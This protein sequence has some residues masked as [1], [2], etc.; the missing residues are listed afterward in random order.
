MTGPRAGY[1]SLGSNLGDRRANLR[2]GLAALDAGGASV[3][4]LSSLYETAPVGL[5]E[6]PQGDFLNLVGAISTTLEPTELLALCKRVEADLGR[7]PSGPRHGPRPLDADILTLGEIRL[8]SGELTIPHVSMTERRFVLE[9]LLELDPSAAL[10]DGRAL[11][12]CLAALPPER[13]ERLGRL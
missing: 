7:D 5:Y 2:A 10:P 1:L 6:G 11:A 9:P 4:E 13:V 12:D 3:T 8:R